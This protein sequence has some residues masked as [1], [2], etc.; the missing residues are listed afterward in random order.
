M[1]KTAKAK[2]LFFLLTFILISAFA[3]H[4]D[5]YQTY[6]VKKGDTLAAISDKFNLDAKQI[7]KDNHLSS[8]K[9]KAGTK[10]KIAVKDEAVSLRGNK[11][12]VYYTV[13]KGETLETIAEKYNMPVQDIKSLNHI[14]TK[15]KS[16]KAGQKIIIGMMPRIHNTAQTKKGSAED[17]FYTVKKG[18]TL[19]RIAR[20]HDLTLAELKELN[21]ITREKIRPGQKILVG[22][23][24]REEEYTV[25]KGDT[26]LR[27]AKKFDLTPEKLKELNDLDSDTL[28]PGQKLVLKQEEEETPDNG[29]NSTPKPEGGAA[30]AENSYAMQVQT[31]DNQLQRA[32]EEP[33]FKE[34]STKDKLISFARMLLNI[35]YRFGGNSLYGIDCSA[36]VQKVFTVLNIKLPRTAREQFNKGITVSMDQ[37]SIG[38]L[39][40]FRTYASFPSHV[41][42]YIGE[43]LF[44][45][46]SSKE[47]KVTIDKLNQPFYMKRF[48]AAKRLLEDEA[49]Q[50]APDLPIPSVKD[51]TVPTL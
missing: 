10:L 11:E 51:Q 44:I 3:R 32:V 46:A 15:K 27:V 2:Y 21:G 19:N 18:D 5:A 28:Q 36:F 17:E 13:Q 4:S 31:L 30:T 24:S 48:I 25:R 39:V 26:L 9:L 1:K 23:A 37:L 22:K 6:I 42:I 47:R 43:N 29:S 45:H 35:P 7:K 40:F 34:L 38:D 41:G 16:L 8:G 12:P 50:L 49:P 33:A 20:G 14:R